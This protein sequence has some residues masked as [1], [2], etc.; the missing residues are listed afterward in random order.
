MLTNAHKQ[1]L[2]FGFFDKVVSSFHK[3][4]LAEKGRPHQGPAFFCRERCPRGTAPYF[5]RANTMPMVPGPEYPPMVV[6]MSVSSVCA[7]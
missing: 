2:M 6:P 3:F 4:L 1:R 5:L 7:N